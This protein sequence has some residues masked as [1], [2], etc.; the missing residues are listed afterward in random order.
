MAGKDEVE[1]VAGEDKDAKGK[2]GEK[3]GKKSKGPKTG[4][5]A[6]LF[7]AEAEVGSEV[8][9]DGSELLIEFPKPLKEWRLGRRACMLATDLMATYAKQM[10]VTRRNA[11]EAD[12]A[13]FEAVVTVNRGNVVVRFKDPIK[14]WRITSKPAALRC[15]GHMRVEMKSLPQ[16]S[17]GD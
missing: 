10:P 1:F 7:D 11:G 3:K 16:T 15:I 2:D 5:D 17:A 13:D 8:G 9:L 14:K 6:P 12:D 4:G